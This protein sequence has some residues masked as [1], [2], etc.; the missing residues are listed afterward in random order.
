MT[1][2]TLIATAALAASVAPT[3]PAA[4]AGASAA[5]VPQ[6]PDCPLFA[7]RP[8]RERD[9]VLPGGDRVVVRDPY[10]GLLPRNRL[11]FA[12]YVKRPDGG[13][14]TGVAKVTWAL[15]GEIKRSD[16]TP[17]FGWA[18]SSG[19]SRRMPAGD[20]LVT[21]TVTPTGGGMPVTTSFPLTAT[22]CQPAYTLSFVGEI[23]IGRPVRGS[24]LFAT[25]SFE[26]GSG[27]T[28]RTV[29]FDST[30]VSVRIP[31]GIRGRVAGTLRIGSGGRHRATTLTLRVP[32]RGTTLLSRGSLRV[33]LHPGSRRFLTVHGLPPGTRE[34]RV[35]LIGKGGQNLLEARRTGPNRCRY[36]VSAEIAGPGGAVRVAG[37]VSTCTSGRVGEPP[38]RSQR[39]LLVHT[40]LVGPNRGRPPGHLDPELDPA[41]TARRRQEERIPGRTTPSA[42]RG[43]RI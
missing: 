17:P 36:S 31:I 35:R 7:R 14:P 6:P 20:H 24:E 25:S 39:K 3:S 26:S 8:A 38:L 1:K 33:V 43:D 9:L 18:G 15:D 22:D 28:M 10:G 41:G 5:A 32:A 29:R 13:S 37:G 2:T 34:A 19:S 23:L 40:S 30:D 16:P 42:D 11:F 12:F 21:V 4:A 27:P